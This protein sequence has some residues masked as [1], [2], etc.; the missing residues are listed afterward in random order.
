MI[1]LLTLAL[2][3]YA[4][5]FVIASSSIAE[6]FRQ[7]LMPRTPKLKIRQHKHFIECR[8]CV[9]FWISLAVCNYDW[10]MILP[11]YGLAYFLATQER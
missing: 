4:V 8:M 6:P 1:R 11:V 7:W 5:T 9:S 3:V 2:T 10:R